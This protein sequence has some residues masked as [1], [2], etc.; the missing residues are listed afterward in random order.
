MKKET[1][2]EKTIRLYNSTVKL[3][4]GT[5]RKTL[6]GEDLFATKNYIM[7]HRGEV[8]LSIFGISTVK[9]VKRSERER[10]SSHGEI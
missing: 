6:V 2:R 3:T 5:W 7:G 10:K 1:R 4:T 8:C 9:G